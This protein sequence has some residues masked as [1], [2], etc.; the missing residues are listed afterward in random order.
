MLS[1]ISDPQSKNKFIQRVCDSIWSTSKYSNAAIAG[2]V[3]DGSTTLNRFS[4]SAN[5]DVSVNSSTSL[6]TM[7]TALNSNYG[8]YKGDDITI[9]LSGSTS[10][11]TATLTM[12]SGD[13]DSLSTTYKKALLQDICNDLWDYS[14]Y[15]NATVTLKVVDSSSTLESTSVDAGGTVTL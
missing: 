10:S 4:V 9:G 14:A 8:S 15:S 12:D 7:E 2:Y 5:G 6:S 3:M 11:L 13:W 1:D